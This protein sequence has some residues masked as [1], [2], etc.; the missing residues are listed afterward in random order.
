MLI[1]QIT[2][3]HIVEPGALM[4][5]RIDPTVGL[6]AAIELI[7]RLDPLPDLVLATGDLVNDGAPA[8]YDQL[9]S[10]LAALSVPLLAIPGN[11]DVR[12]HM[13]RCFT[14][15]PSGGSDE[16]IDYVVD[17]YAVRLIGLDTSI[18]GRNDGRVTA[19]QMQWLDHQ[20]SAEPERPTV[21]FQHHPPFRS[22]IPWMDRDSGFGGAELEANVLSRHSHVEAVVCGHLHRAIHRRFGGTVASSWPSTAVQLSLDLR[23]GAPSYTDEPAA[24]A[25][26]EYVDGSLNSHVVPVAPADRWTPNW[27]L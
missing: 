6:S 17:E 23:D 21:I 18:P 25:L 3:C 26:H 15:L 22:G 5:D 7:N 2:D 13:R 14:S 11:H 27:A 20:L 19:D 10:L 1:A 8:Q 9:M 4:A 24:I 12:S 16:P